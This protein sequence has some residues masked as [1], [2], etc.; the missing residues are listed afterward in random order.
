MPPTTKSSK[1]SRE[2]TTILEEHFRG[3]VPLTVREMT[4]EDEDTG[5]RRKII[6]LVAGGRDWEATRAEIADKSSAGPDTGAD[7]PICQ[8]RR[9]TRARP[10]QSSSSHGLSIPQQVSPVSP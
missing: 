1:V 5:K 2:Y 4:A 10:A 6:R 9:T 3:P 7:R 8:A